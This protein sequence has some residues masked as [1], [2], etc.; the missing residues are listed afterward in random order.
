VTV[1]RDG[2][3]MFISFEGIEGSG[4][5]TQALLLTEFLSSRGYRTFLT[6]EP[7][8]TAIGDRIRE[9]LLDP[10]HREMT[11]M[12]ELLLY[13]AARAQHLREGILPAL[14]EGLIVITDRFSDST[15]AYQGY[16][17]CLDAAAIAVLDAVATGGE[18]PDLTILLDL[19]VE[20]GVTRN[21][22]VKKTDRLEM[23]EEEFHE[24][25]RGGFLEIAAADPQRVKVVDAS[26]TVEAVSRRVREIVSSRLPA[27][28]RDPS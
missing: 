20:R 16:G 26:G 25:V 7:G 19:P 27:M 23:E 24:R 10:E 1:R 15:T 2:A 13:E 9:L 11:P 12:T 8:G 17:R 22:E 5:T 6:R 4:K 18:K 28:A 3:G 21:R 14:Q